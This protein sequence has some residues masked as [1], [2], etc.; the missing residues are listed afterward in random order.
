MKRMHGLSVYEEAYAMPYARCILQFQSLAQNLPKPI[1]PQQSTPAPA[2]VATFSV[3]TPAPAPPLPAWRPGHCH[4]QPTLI[5]SRSAPPIPPPVPEPGQRDVHFC[6]QPSHLVL[7]CPIA[8][9]Y[10]RLGHTL[11]LGDRLCLPYGQ[12]IPPLDAD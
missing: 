8:Q 11:V 5:P 10:V 12:Q 9:E 4:S 6:L 2:S 7:Q 3:Q 1:F